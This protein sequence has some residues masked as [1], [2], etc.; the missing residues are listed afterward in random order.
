[1]KNT[2]KILLTLALGILMTLSCFAAEAY[3]DAQGVRYT[4]DEATLTAYVGGAD[5]VNN[6]S[7]Y[8]G[9]GDVV[10][11]SSITHNEKTYTVDKIEA[12]AFSTSAVKTVSIP[13]SVKEIGYSAFAGC[14]KLTGFTVD[15]A[16]TAFMTIDGD[17]YDKKTSK[18]MYAYADGNARSFFKVPDGV[19]TIASGAFDGTKNLYGI[20]LNAVT[21]TGAFAFANSSVKTAYCTAQ[22]INAGTFANSDI[23]TVVV[24]KTSLFNIGAVAFYGCDKLKTVVLPQVRAINDEAF[25]DCTALE[26]IVICKSGASMT[27]GSDAFKNVPATCKIVYSNVTT[28]LNAA[29]EN[30]AS[31]T[32]TTSGTTLKNN[33]TFSNMISTHTAF[34]YVEDGKTD[35]NI[36]FSAFN[37]TETTKEIT[38]YVAFY[39]SDGQLVDVAITETASV[40]PFNSVDF[41]V[42]TSEEYASASI[43]LLDGAERP[44]GVNLKF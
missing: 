30:M 8:T 19:K 22:T 25:M 29:A 39:S 4:L 43:I 15:A 1:M 14:T 28:A 35:K 5:S 40:M 6:T 41:E 23:E 20:N 3:V 11:P 31:A 36:V 16:S 44:V 32:Y 38:A 17:L 42:S 26:K 24:T 21:T 13:S 27:V 2:A 12:F 9:T 33:S 7:R 18:T 34:A 37:K 10:I